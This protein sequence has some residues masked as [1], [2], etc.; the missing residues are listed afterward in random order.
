MGRGGTR[1][2]RIPADKDRER[3]EEG[4]A[5]R[6]VACFRGPSRGWTAPAP[7]RAAKAWH[8]AR[9]PDLA[10][11]FLLSDPRG[12]AESAFLRVP[13][14]RPNPEGLRHAARFRQRHP[15]R[16]HAGRGP[17]LRRRRGFR[18]RGID[19]L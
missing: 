6:W 5:A 1:I 4:M 15:A 2:R 7:A 14:G 9:Q 11:L 8:T 18:L 16:V 17:G 13:F 10:F 3:A 19:V 12:S